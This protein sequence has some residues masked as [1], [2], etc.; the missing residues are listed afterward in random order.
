MYVCMYVCT[1]VH[2]RMYIY[3]CM[4][5]CMYVR[6]YVCMYV[7]EQQREKMTSDLCTQ[8][9]LKS[10]C[11]SAPSDQS[12]RCPREENLHPQDSGMHQV[13]ILIRLRECAD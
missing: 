5:E 2:V 10:A 13:K 12:L 6:T 11:A 7:C 1:Y 9:R 4:S 3:I 8:P